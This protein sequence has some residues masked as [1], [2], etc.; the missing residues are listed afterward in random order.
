MVHEKSCCCTALFVVPILNINQVLTWLD[1]KWC[2]V[3][4]ERIICFLMNQS[5]K[6]QLLDQSN[7]CFSANAEHGDYHHMV[8]NKAAQHASPSLYCVL[9][10]RQAK[11]GS[12]RSL[13]IWVLLFRHIFN[14]VSYWYKVLVMSDRWLDIVAV[15]VLHPNHAILFCYDGTTITITD[16][17]SC[18][19]LLRSGATMDMWWYCGGK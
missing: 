1:N 2:K 12:L 5:E 8:G 15:N 6:F 10:T 18:A 13:L 9:D 4:T 17:R 16:M 19:V 7:V 11:V 3:V 14:L